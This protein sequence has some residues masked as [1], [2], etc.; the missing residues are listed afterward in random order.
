MTKEEII[1]ALGLDDA[2]DEMKNSIVDN[3]AQIAETRLVLLL[4]E[5]LSDEQRA[6]FVELEASE[7]K[8]AAGNWFLA[9]FPQLQEIYVGIIKDIIDAQLERLKRLK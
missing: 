1:T 5:I 2:S 6:R 7:D 8:D 9:E 3:I 4:D